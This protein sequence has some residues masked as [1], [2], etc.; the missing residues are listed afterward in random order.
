MNLFKILTITVI[1]LN[2]LLI[3]YYLLWYYWIIPHTNLIYTLYLIISYSGVISLI[4]FA[5]VAITRIRSGFQGTRLMIGNRHLH[6]GTI[7]IVFVIIGVIWNIWH[8][9][10]EK[11][12]FDEGEYATM[13]WWL[14]VGGLVFIVIGAILVGRDWEDI[15][16]F[17]FFNKEDEK[18]KG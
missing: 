17:R 14:A 9:F 15:R 11:F 3:P 18:P 16:N 5:C 6:E 1:T 12:F 4:F 10:D 7:G 13:G 2:I 8:F